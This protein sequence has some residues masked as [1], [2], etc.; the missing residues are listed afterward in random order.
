M[1]P[2]RKRFPDQPKQSPRFIH[3]RPGRVVAL[4]TTIVLLSLADLYITLVYLH[5][6]GMSEANPVARWIMGH[7]SAALLSFWKL[8]TVAVAVLIFYNARHTR[9]GEIGAWSCAL[10]LTWLTVQWISYSDEIHK[11]TSTLHVLADHEH[12]K[13]ITMSPVR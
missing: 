1:R 2:N 7:G 3:A 6:G 4:A 9:A 13:W 12:S 5:S 10:L 11:I 8:A